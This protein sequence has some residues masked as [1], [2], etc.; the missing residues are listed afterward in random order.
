MGNSI[1]NPIVQHVAHRSHEVRRPNPKGRFYLY[2]LLLVP[3]RSA[4][5]YRHIWLP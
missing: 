5:Q 4:I 2:A 1:E 3:V